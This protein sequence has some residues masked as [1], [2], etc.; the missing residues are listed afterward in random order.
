MVDFGYANA[1]V[2][3]H[4]SYLLNQAFFEKL[5]DAP[6]FEEALN[7]LLQTPYK[8][9][10][11]RGFLKGRNIEGAEEGLKL[12]FVR[13]MR[14]LYRWVDPPVRKL[15]DIIF[16]RWDVH[17]LKTILRGKHHGVS[18]EEMK[19][20]FFAVG[21]LSEALLVELAKQ[22]DIRAVIDLLATWESPY[23]LPLTEVFPEYHEEG[24]LMILE[25]ALDKFYYAH[26]LKELRQ[27]NLSV[28]LVREVV[29]REIDFVNLMSLMKGV[30]ER[31]SQEEIESFFISGGKFITHERYLEL[32]ASDEL[33]DVVEGLRKTPYEVPLREGFKDFA[34]KG[35]LSY[36]E[37]RMEE[38]II[39]SVVSLFK[40]DPL[41]IAIILAYIWAKFNE[42]VNLRIVLRGKAVGMRKENIREALVFV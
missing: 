12:N 14:S 24:R 4:K 34:K 11:E 35:L 41:S 29:R 10:L 25:L 40:A 38:Y 8:P 33:E 31:L 28:Q 6:S 9:D 21:T 27:R 23:A 18:L 20:S 17:N 7:I 1:R 37:R 13:E 36:V 32:A 22:A 19:E 5:M 15:L 39:K 2:R 3:A 16:G 30:R 42:I 26:S